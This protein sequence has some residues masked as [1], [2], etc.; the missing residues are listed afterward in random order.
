MQSTSRF[1][2]STTG[3]EAKNLRRAIG[4]KRLHALPYR[5]GFDVLEST[6][7]PIDSVLTNI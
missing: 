4:G 5:A 3:N 6:T 1:G 7:H 2:D